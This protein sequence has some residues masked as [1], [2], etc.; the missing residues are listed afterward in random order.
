MINLA[1][2]RVEHKKHAQCNSLK[3]IFKTFQLHLFGM[4]AQ[5]SLLE[6]QERRGDVTKDE[7]QIEIQTE[8]VFFL[9]SCFFFLGTIPC[10]HTRG[11]LLPSMCLRIFAT[12]LTPQRKHPKYCGLKID[13]YFDLEI[14]LPAFSA[15]TFTSFGFPNMSIFWFSK[16]FIIVN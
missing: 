13:L 15:Y 2:L 4:H 6:R 12:E 1:Y 10:P 7:K 8:S 11:T 5:I 14:H 16:Y 3:A 9:C